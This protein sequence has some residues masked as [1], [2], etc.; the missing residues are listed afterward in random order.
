MT[1]SEE[2]AFLSGAGLTFLVML[3]IVILGIMAPGC[4][5]VVGPSTHYLSSPSAG[6]GVCMEIWNDSAHGKVVQCR[7][8]DAVLQWL[9]SQNR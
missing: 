2:S 5:F 9:R 3:V 8:A 7:D 4:D 6:G 1:G